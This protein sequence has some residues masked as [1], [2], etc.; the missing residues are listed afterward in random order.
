M[1]AALYV[2]LTY[3]SSLFGLSSGAIQLR[4][5]E[6]LCVLAMFSPSAIGGLFVGCIL[7]N[8]LFGGMLVDVIFGSLATLIGAVGTYLLRRRPALI[9]LICPVLSNTLIIPFVITYAYGAEESLWFIFLTVG[10]GEV[11]SCGVLGALL[12]GALKKVKFF[13]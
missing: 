5:S 12:H 7:S 4:L 3:A 9:A 11:I 8:M 1:I 10:T 6:A 13:I 2:V